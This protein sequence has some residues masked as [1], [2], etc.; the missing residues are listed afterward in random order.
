MLNIFLARS[1]ISDGNSE[2][3]DVIPVTNFTLLFSAMLD[4]T[5]S[6]RSF[7]MILLTE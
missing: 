3:T 5:K 7:M 1:I 6:D 2:L 4:A